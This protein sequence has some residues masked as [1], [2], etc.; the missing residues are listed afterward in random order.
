MTEATKKI[1]LPAYLQRRFEA[2]RIVKGNAQSYIIRDKVQD[3]V[4]DFDPW[5]FFILEI[6]PGSDSFERLQTSF[7]DRFDRKLTKKELDE[8]LGSIADRKMFDDTAAEHPLLKPFMQRTYKVEDGKAVPKPFVEAPA[9]TAAPAS[10]AATPA[11]A[12]A[13]AAAAPVQ[14]ENAELPAGVQDALGMDWRTTKVMLGLFDPR[15][16]L[17][18]LAP[19]LR[20]LRHIIYAVPLLLL[21]ALFLMYQYFDLLTTDLTALHVDVNLFQHLLFLFVTL[22]VVV[23]LTVGS[24]AHAFKVSV[25]KVGFALAFGFMPRWA[26]KMTGADRL[27]RLQT[28]WLHG[29]ALLARVVLFSLGIIVWFNTRDTD[30][31]LATAGLLLMFGCAAG[32]LLESGNPLVKAN[33]YYLLS[34]YLNEPHLRGKAYAALLNK[35]RGGV[36][37]AADST[38]LVLYALLSTTYVILIIVVVG[39][40]LAKFI[41]GDLALGGS[42]VILTLFFVGYLLYRNYAGLKRFGETYE[43]QVQF[44]RWRSRT[45]PVGAVEGEVTRDKPNYWQRALLVCLLLALFIPYPYEAGGSFLIFPARKQVVSTDESGLVEAVYFEGGEAVKQ[46]T[47]LARLAHVDYQSQI[48]VLSAK[49]DEQKAVIDNL[50][51]LPK[52]QEVKLAEQKLE[53]ERSREKFSREKAPR[54]E[55]LYKVGAVSFE[56]FDSARKDHLSDVEQVAQKEAELALV[57][58]PVTV[59]Q[60]AAAEAKLASLV[61]ER[62][63][64]EVKIQRTVLQMPFDGNILTLHL[65]DKINSYLEKGAPFAALEDT[66]VVTAEIEVPESDLQYVKIGSAIRARPVSFADDKEFEGKVTVID[67]NV[68]PKSTGNVV[69]VIAAIDNRAGLLKTGMAGRAKVVGVSMPVWRAFSLAI[70][71]FIKIQ[72]WSWIP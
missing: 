44:D 9:S 20:P 41:L 28:M 58:A 50:K 66:S 27:T 16:A 53:V 8:L 3:K 59:S 6:L 40:M 54:L 51:T 72:V 57:K 60:I 65:K 5:Q 37:R 70:V 67:R 23:S 4:H 38:L 36:Y 31:G 52:P 29:S 46:G 19:V 35:I 18:L 69:K 55:K 64:Y 39:W 71:R 11:P 17:T 10:A 63:S 49:I 42:A 7:E 24:V 61:E 12:A 15:P 33:G 48:K 32:L 22:H 1:V 68:T 30:N 2:F 26:L 34:A 25:D 13:P 21:A 47:V 56:E 45:L 14:D 62:A 43:R